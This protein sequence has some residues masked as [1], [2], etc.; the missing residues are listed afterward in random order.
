MTDPLKA[1]RVLDMRL[2]LVR[3]PGMERPPRGWIRAIRDALGLTTRQFGARMGVSQPR[4]VAM[5]RGELDESLTLASLRRAA[6]AL[7][8]ELVYAFV[9]KEPL[10]DTMQARAKAKADNQLRRVGHT[11]RLENQALT[12]SNQARH[13][14]NLIEQYLSGN[15][16]RLWDDVP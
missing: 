8:C 9:P 6:E 2:S 14:E 16:A 15:L 5:E 1:A 11:M 3:K 4:A 13:R 10:T 7:G 12:N